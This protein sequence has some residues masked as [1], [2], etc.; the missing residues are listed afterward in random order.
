MSIAACIAA[1]N[2]CEDWLEELKSYLDENFRFIKDYLEKYISKAKMNI[3]EGTYLAWVDLSG[4]AKKGEELSREIARA[5][6]FIEYENEFVQDGDGH[7]RINIACPRS[8]LEEGLK[9]IADALGTA[10]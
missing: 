2:Q 9:R 7:V 5:G 1:Y 3:P 8:I 10:V 6:V 4:Y